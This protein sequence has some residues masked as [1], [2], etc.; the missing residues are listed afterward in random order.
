MAYVTSPPA[1]S[2]EY[3]LYVV[4]LE[5]QV[6]EWVLDVGYAGEAVRESRAA[7]VF[8][9]DRSMADRL[10]AAPPILDP[11]RTVVVEGAAR[12]GGDGFYGK[13]EFS[14]AMGQH[15]RLTLAG[16]GLG[17]NPTTS[18]VS[19]PGIPT[20]RHGQIQ[21]LNLGVPPRVSHGPLVDAGA[22]AAMVFS[23]PLE[24]LSSAAEAFQMAVEFL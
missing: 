3:V 12:Q 14:Q 5:R 11:R 15:W 6:G 24:C 16:V 20:L 19:T 21:L 1:T 10:S 4:E 23:Q 8:A 22:M 17:G 2:D 9:P 13:F 7:R 18:W